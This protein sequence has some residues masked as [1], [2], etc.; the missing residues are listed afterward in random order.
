MKLH[1]GAASQPEG[2]LIQV[3]ASPPGV[4]TALPLAVQGGE[5][6][7]GP[8]LKRVREVK[9]T[10]FALMQRIVHL[11]G[12]AFAA[13]ETAAGGLCLSISLP[14]KVVAPVAAPP[15]ADREEEGAGADG[16]PLILLVDDQVALLEITADY[17][18]HQGFRVCTAADGREALEQ[19]EALLPDL[20]I[21]DTQM[22]GMDGIEAISHLRKSSTPRVA[23]VPIISLSGMGGPGDKE[24]C[25]AAGASSYLA[26]PFGVKALEAVVLEFLRLPPA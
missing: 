24:S 9:P 6:A 22:P 12:G 5:D 15:P 17:L 20:V 21:M 16:T 23:T 3:A 18:R 1:L 4:A 19:A 11:H 8:L 13:Q 7:A 2:L 14:L 26:K 10:G 25:L